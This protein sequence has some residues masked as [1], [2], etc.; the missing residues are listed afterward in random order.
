MHANQT[1]LVMNKEKLGD[2]AATEAKQRDH[3]KVRPEDCNGS[4]YYVLR[5]LYRS[6]LLKLKIYQIMAFSWLIKYEIKLNLCILIISLFQ[7]K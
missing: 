1:F 3:A 6:Y 5:T 7:I 4:L 2:L